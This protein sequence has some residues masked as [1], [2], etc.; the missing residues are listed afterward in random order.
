MN[1]NT[2]YG[3][4]LLTPPTQ[5]QSLTVVPRRD[6]QDST[7]DF[8]QTFQSVH[9]DTP[10]ENNASLDRSTSKS[11][12]IKEPVASGNQASTQTQNAN[13]NSTQ[14]TDSASDAKNTDVSAT[15][16][17]EQTAAQK[18]TKKGST[19]ATL[20]NQQEA[21][22]DT[23]GS[24]DD[25]SAANNLI[26]AGI[27]AVPT[28]PQMNNTKIGFGQLNSSTA[29]VADTADK[30][31]ATNTDSA[32][33]T[34]K[35]PDGQQAQLMV[36]L[37]SE[38][39]QQST[40]GVA[41]ATAGS[42]KILQVQTDAGKKLIVGSLRS[43]LANTSPL[44][45]PS[46]TA[47]QATSLATQVAA[48]PTTDTNVSLKEDVLVAALNNK[49]ADSIASNT[50]DSQLLKAD[51]AG[52]T[53]TKEQASTDL[54]T[55]TKLT[56]EKMLQSIGKADTSPT[57]PH[58]QSSLSNSPTAAP[59]N[60]PMDSLLNSADTHTPATRSFVVQTAVPVTVG[61]PQWSQ[62]VGEKV[63]WLAAQNVS[64]AEIHLHPQ[65]LGP[66]Q[67]NVS[68]NQDQANVTF[69]SHH[70]VVREALDQNLN[71]LR[72]MFSEQGL[73]L[74]NVDVSDK[75]FS[76]QQSDS[77]G[78]KGQGGGADSLV[79]EEDVVAVS[80]IVSQRLVDHYA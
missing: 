28:Q 5:S 53:S 68:V 36:A 15:T 78:G 4:V 38:V 43:S 72:D 79:D 69:T 20:S 75:S 63:L 41:E 1:G 12:A 73:N 77:K 71:R 46:I 50:S 59:V 66:V 21:S 2:A 47:D 32:G 7:S 65:D 52:V 17:G 11:A 6:A 8:N 27:L 44:A 54:T 26:A 31:D 24:T 56:F 74:V 61:Q 76:R 60:S 34:Q 51:A 3:N 30:T 62:A 29:S 55:D 16:S 14:K 49:S 45:Q 64:S 22:A 70:P 48:A 40:A 18:N 33:G 58:S 37:A 42:K 13:A 19:T 35:L 10:K 39:G 57:D 23:I 25:T 9:E 67:V 80:P